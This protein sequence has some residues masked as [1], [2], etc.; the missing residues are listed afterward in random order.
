MA[1][2]GKMTHHTPNGAIH[3]SP[4][5][6]PSERVQKEGYDWR[7]VGENIARGQTS[8]EQVVTDWLE[9]PGHCANIMKSTFTEIGLGYKKSANGTPYWTQDFAAPR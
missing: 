1:A 7:A 2:A 9:S 3:Y 5:T 4:G 6:K 8:A